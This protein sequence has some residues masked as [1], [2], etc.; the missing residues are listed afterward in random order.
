[1]FISNFI[2]ISTVQINCRA[3]TSLVVLFDTAAFIERFTS[4]EL[5]VKRFSK[6]VE[7]TVVPAGKNIMENIE[8]NVLRGTY[9]LDEALFLKSENVVPRMFGIK[10]IFKIIRALYAVHSYAM[11]DG[12][13]RELFFRVFRE[14]EF[15]VTVLNGTRLL[16]MILDNSQAKTQM[17]CT[18]SVTTP[19]ESL[20]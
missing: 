8:A 16:L 10:K 15:L 4:I 17:P 12:W 19:F 14:S 13:S 9:T 3:L 2:A 18:M 5:P 20:L 7:T 6:S 11:K 1:M